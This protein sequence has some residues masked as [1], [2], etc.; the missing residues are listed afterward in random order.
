MEDDANK[1]TLGKGG[2]LDR[3]LGLPSSIHNHNKT[4]SFATP[5]PVGMIYNILTWGDTYICWDGL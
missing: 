3:I 2:L 4:L 5:T 1:Q